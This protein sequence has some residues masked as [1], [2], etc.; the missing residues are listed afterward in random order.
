MGIKREWTA[1]TSIAELIEAAKDIRDNPGTDCHGTVGFCAIELPKL[2]RLRDALARLQPPDP[3]EGW[4]LLEVGETSMQGDEWHDGNEWN[5][6]KYVMKLT[7]NSGLIRRRLPR[8]R[9]F[10]NAKEFET[11]RDR[12]FRRKASEVVGKIGSYGPVGVYSSDGVFAT[13]GELFEQAV[14]DDDGTPCGV[15]VE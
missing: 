1:E 12:W 3:G 10:A 6:C 11:H 8:Y 2:D 14:F 7:N 15:K 5:P 9:P 13:Y 4:R